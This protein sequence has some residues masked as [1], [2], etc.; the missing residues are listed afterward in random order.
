MGLLGWVGYGWFRFVGRWCCVGFGC[1]VCWGIFLVGVVCCV[2][3][4]WWRFWRYVVV[5]GRCGFLSGCRW[6]GWVVGCF[7]CGMVL[8]FVVVVW[9]CFLVCSDRGFFWIGSSSRC[10]VWVGWCGWWCCWFWLLWSFCWWI[11]CWWCGG[12]GVCCVCGCWLLVFVFYCCNGGRK[13]RM[14]VFV[15][16]VF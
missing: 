8:M 12:L 14:V 2:W 13:L 11:F 5:C 15:W 3:F 6:V 7:L 10:W 9:W 4:C 1:L 16:S